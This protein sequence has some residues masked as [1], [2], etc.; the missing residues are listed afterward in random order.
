MTRRKCFISYHHQDAA[1]VRAFVDRFSDVLIAK[2]IGE[3]VSDDDNF[4]KSNDTEYVLRSIREKYLSDSTVT[5]V[6]I[7]RCTWE[8]KYVDWEIAS[9]LRHDPNNG[10][11][12]LVGVTL[13]SI[14]NY[15]GTKAPARLQTNAHINETNDGYARWMKYPSSAASLTSWIEDAYSARTDAA[16]VRL[17]Q[18]RG[19]LKTNNSPCAH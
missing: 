16:R 19:G 1:E 6:M 5:I 15:D 18:P 3:G 4:V 2:G 9:T 11:S 14:A 17:I 8:R 12:G 10:R 7:G 13:P